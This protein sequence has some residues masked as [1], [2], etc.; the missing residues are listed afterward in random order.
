MLL[1]LI[2]KDLISRNYYYYS[3]MRKTGFRVEMTRQVYV[4][5]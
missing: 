3:N 5:I 1:H 4:V 2:Y